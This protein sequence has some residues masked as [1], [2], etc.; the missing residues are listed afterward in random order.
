MAQQVRAQITRE[1]LI[2]GAAEAFTRLGYISATT[3]DIARAAGATRG[4][5]YFHFQ[6]KEEIARAV[7]DKEQRLAVESGT[8]I[9]ELGRPALETMLLLSVD[10][11]ERMQA[12]P[13]VKAGIRLTTENSNFDPPL[14]A[15]YE[16]WLATFGAIAGLAVEQGDFRHDLDPAMFAR[17]LIPAYTGIQLVSDTFS[18]RADL[19]PRIREMWLFIFPAVV[20]AERIENAR[21]VLDRLI[22]V[23]R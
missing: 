2:D 19:L 16:Q 4:A 7:V 23:T 10:L 11:A 6:S 22:S 18:G 21:A 1:R 20:P 15:P 5:L 12:D 14:R 3:T 17:F 8:R 9:V 13:V